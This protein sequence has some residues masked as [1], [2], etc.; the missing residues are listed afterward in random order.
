MICKE[1]KIYPNHKKRVPDKGN[2]I[3][4]AS[5]NSAKTE[6]ENLILREFSR[7][8][9]DFIA[10]I[11]IQKPELAEILVEIVFENKN[12]L[13]KRAVWSLQIAQKKNKHLLKNHI[14]KIISKLSEVRSHSVQR[15][16]L[17]VL[18]TATIPEEKKGFLLD[19][20]T[21]ILTNK[22]STVAALIYSIDIYYNI[23]KKE[24]E[25]LN[26]LAIMLEFLQPDATPGIASKSRRIMNQIYKTKM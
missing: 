5:M 22:N 18:T 23:A 26:E 15:C 6:L 3:K 21:E 13:A 14:K 1:R 11:I 9:A 12:P 8:H 20:T 7:S 2:S 10:D 16:L 25:L 24:P 19:Y 4:F 17:S